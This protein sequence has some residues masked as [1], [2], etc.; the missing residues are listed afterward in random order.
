MMDLSYALFIVVIVISIITLGLLIIG[1]SVISIAAFRILKT[2][3]DKL[4]EEND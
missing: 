4:R 3:N 2:L 1:G